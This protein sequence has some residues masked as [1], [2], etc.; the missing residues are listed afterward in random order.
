MKNY[1]VLREYS[2]TYEGSSVS[3]D[4]LQK[5]SYLEDLRTNRLAVEKQCKSLVRI[6][7]QWQQLGSRVLP[8]LGNGESWSGKLDFARYWQDSSE[9]IKMIAED[10]EPNPGRPIFVEIRGLPQPKL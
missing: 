8:T 6:V 3:L 5:P 10:V 2:H 1:P 7:A 4:D 9:D